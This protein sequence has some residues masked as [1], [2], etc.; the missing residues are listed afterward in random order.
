[1]RI[2]VHIWAYALR[3]WL[4]AVTA[5]YAAFWLQLGGASSAT[6]TVAILAQPT[7]GAA[8]SKP[9][10]RLAATFIGATM[11]IV[12]A[13]LFPGER[14]GLLLSFICWICI[15][16]FAASYLRGYRAYAAVLS[17]YTVAIITVAN[18]D[19]PAKRVHNHDRSRGGDNDRHPLRDRYQRP[20]RFAVGMVRIGSQDKR[21]L[22]RRPRVCAWGF[23]E[24]AGGSRKDR[25]AIV[26]DSGVE[27]R[28]RCG[29][30]RHG[31]LAL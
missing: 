2:P 19:T 14:L 1:M 8:L 18:I 4:A 23:G 13:G 10:Y 16:V 5:L 27:G 26:A 17:G 22:A 6:V 7:R 30:L 12:I 15:C 25:R 28:H 11:S 9:A 31:G 29:R 3:I 24:R 20:L 21:H